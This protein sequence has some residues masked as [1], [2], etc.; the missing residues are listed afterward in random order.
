MKLTRDERRTLRTRKHLH[1][2]GATVSASTCPRCPA[3]R[4]AAA[5]VTGAWPVWFPTQ[6]PRTFLSCPT[7]SL[8]WDVRT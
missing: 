7:C 8:L 5:K 4:D 3:W 6:P 2:T 1:Y